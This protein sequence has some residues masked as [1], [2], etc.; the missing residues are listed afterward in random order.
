MVAAMIPT[1]TAHGTAMATA[2]IPGESP[3]E[4]D[5]V[6]VD[7]EFPLVLTMVEPTTNVC[8]AQVLVVDDVKT[9]RD[10]VVT[11]GQPGLNW[12]KSDVMS[13]VVHP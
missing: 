5:A 12:L 11:V 3:P 4:D 1:T 10:D 7:V 6:V 13:T 9:D 2:S 8:G